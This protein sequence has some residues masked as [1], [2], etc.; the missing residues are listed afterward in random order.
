MLFAH[1]YRDATAIVPNLLCRHNIT[2]TSQGPVTG[3]RAFFYAFHV[4][5][6]HSQRTHVAIRI[7]KR[8][9]Y[10]MEHLYI[11]FLAWLNGIHYITNSQPV[12]MCSSFIWLAIAV[13]REDSISAVQ[14]T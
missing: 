11:Q 1:I 2:N 6:V 13:S 12:D 5:D 10:S 9:K 8:G 4:V 7:T 14:I 3:Q